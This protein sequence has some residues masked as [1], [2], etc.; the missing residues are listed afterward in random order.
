[1]LLVEDIVD[2]GV[3]LSHLV[4]LMRQRGPQS[5]KVCALLSKPSRRRVDVAVDFLG[6]EIPDAFVVGYGLDYAERYRSL[7]FVAVLKPEVY[8]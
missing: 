6:F 7:P 5:V 4:E 8:R 2:S 3:T 1:V